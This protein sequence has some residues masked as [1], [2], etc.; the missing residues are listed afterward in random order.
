[1]GAGA[2]PGRSVW[3]FMDDWCRGLAVSP[4]H[5]GQRCE[6][7]T[8]RRIR[9]VDSFELA[10]ER[11]FHDQPQLNA[12]V[13]RAAC[14]RTARPVCATRA[15]RWIG[16]S[17]PRKPRRAAL[18]RRTAHRAARRRSLVARAAHCGHSLVRRTYANMPCHA[19]GQA[20][21][22]GTHGSPTGPL[23]IAKLPAARPRSRP[24]SHSAVRAAAPLQAMAACCRT[25]Q[26]PP[27]AAASARR[28]GV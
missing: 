3:Y 12:S 21:R 17:K 10:H 4:W 8:D 26:G 7:S 14:P 18:A 28:C 9:C 23:W 25:A 27:A 2:R 15:P 6:G 1:M 11:V 5:R 22:V 24:P 13:Q 16:L 20:T 19:T